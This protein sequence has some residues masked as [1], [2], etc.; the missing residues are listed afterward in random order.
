MLLALLRPLLTLA[1]VAALAG[2]AGAPAHAVELKVCQADRARYGYRM[3][4]ARLI[5]ARTAAPGETVT[6]RPY[7]RTD[8][9]Q[10]RCVQLLRDR[11]VDL[12]YLPPTQELLARFDAIRIDLHQGMLGYRLLLINRKDA[13][14][15][16]AVKTLDDLRRFTGGFGQ[17]WADFPLFARNRLPVVTAAQSANLLAMLDSGR[18]HYFHRGLHEAWAELAQYP[19]FGDLMV[20]PHL[21]LRYRFPVY[22]MFNRADAQLRERFERGFAQILADGSF[23]KLFLAE[24]GAI[25]YNAQLK[26][27]TI[28]DIDYP[29]PPGLP[30]V[31]TKL[32]L[33]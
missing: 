7:E 18:F 24:F 21:A 8:P 33:E 23:R 1:T 25:A 11:A 20:E 13:D 17:Q 15:F 3:E 4:L 22:F 2:A 19:Q 9:A 5:L 30:P 31:D 28:I 26:D 14:A 27:R 10:Q 12:V 16:A 6:I 32:W 29:L